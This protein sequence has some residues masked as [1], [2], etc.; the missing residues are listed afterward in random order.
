MRRQAWV[1]E[2]GSKEICFSVMKMAPL[3]FS[4][5]LCRLKVSCMSGFGSYLGCYGFLFRFYVIAYV[6]IF[7][8]GLVGDVEAGLFCC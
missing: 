2:G 4:S 8:V 7:E 6:L 3:A 5:R 1:G